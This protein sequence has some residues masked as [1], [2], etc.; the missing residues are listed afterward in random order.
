MNAGVS[1][2]HLALGN[3]EGGEPSRR[4]FVR[5]AALGAVL[6]GGAA[7]VV[8][9]LGGCASGGGGGGSEV[10]NTDGLVPMFPPEGRSTAGVPGPSARPM[11]EPPASGSMGVI[12]RS[13]WAR[14]APIPSR[15]KPMLPVRR[16]TVHHD[17]TDAFW[18]T[19][20]A[21]AATRLEQIRQAHLVRRPEPFGDIGY[22]YAIDPAGRVWEGRN[23]AWQG[24]HVKDQNEGNLGIVVLGNFNRQTVNRAQTEAV[25]QFVALQM[26]R[27]GVAARSVFTHRELAPTE[28]PGNSLQSM[29][30]ACRRSNGALARVLA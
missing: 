21:S 10:G 22:H 19:S 25:Q 13:Q 14:G 1:H 18:G 16:I 24:A 17:G 26:R 8:S 3:D 7:L 4:E 27:Y 23:L 30:V 29:M 12:P 9:G 2:D 11:P 20:T 6:L 28:C 5:R 15:M